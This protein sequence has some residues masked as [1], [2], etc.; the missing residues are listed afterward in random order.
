M[1]SDGADVDDGGDFIQDEHQASLDPSAC[2]R[3]SSLNASNAIQ[4]K[5]SLA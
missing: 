5:G 3:R 4:V 1:S 2:S